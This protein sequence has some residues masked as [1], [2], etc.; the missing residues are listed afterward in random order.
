[1]RCTRRDVEIFEVTSAL[2]KRAAGQSELAVSVTA[3]FC[4][5]TPLTFAGIPHSRLRGHAAWRTPLGFAGAARPQLISISLLP[6]LKNMSSN[7]PPSPNL[8]PDRL[9]PEVS[10]PPNTRFFRLGGSGRLYTIPDHPTELIKVPAPYEWAIRDLEIEKHVYRRLRN[11]RNVIQ[12]L[13]TDE[14]GIYLERASLGSLRE[15]YV[16]GGKA[17]LWDVLI[18]LEV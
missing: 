3:S 7:R 17:T 4:Q 9:L 18:Y 8:P 11:H 10:H 1:M 5:R 12:C 13:R 6:R 2:E 15:Y 16:G 14:Y